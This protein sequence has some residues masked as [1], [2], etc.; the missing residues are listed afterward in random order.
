M[1]R[2]IIS[3]GSTDVM[4]RAGA[5]ERDIRKCEGFVGLRALTWP[6]A[7][8]APNSARTRLPIA[9]SSSSAGGTPAIGEGACA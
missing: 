8:T 1:A 7:S 5:S 9:R 4:R 3:T 6:K 2:Y